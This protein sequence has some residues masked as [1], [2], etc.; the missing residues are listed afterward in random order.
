MS[1]LR[2]LHVTWL[3][4]QGGRSLRVWLTVGSGAGA[5]VGGRCRSS[6]RG[7][8]PVG[9]GCEHEASCIFHNFFIH[10]V[11]LGG[12]TLGNGRWINCFGLEFLPRSTGLLGTHRL[13]TCVRVSPG[14]VPWGS[15]VY[16]LLQKGPANSRLFHRACSSA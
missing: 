2:V 14:F 10:F 6:S 1:E 5:W 16:G 7:G 15:P 4:L 9:G 8:H 13:V 11:H 12:T 3:D